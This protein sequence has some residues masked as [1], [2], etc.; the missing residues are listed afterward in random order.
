[1]NTGFVDFKELVEIVDKQTI[2]DFI[3]DVI[4]NITVQNGNIK[5]ITF[6]NGLKHNFIYKNNIEV[7]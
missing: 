3:N 7:V 6:K 4:S 2:K 5:S 1:M